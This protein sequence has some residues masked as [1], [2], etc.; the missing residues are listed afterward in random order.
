MKK[1]IITF[2]GILCILLATVLLLGFLQ[3]LLMPKYMSTS[4]E[5]GLIAEYY[6]EENPSH[7]VLFIGDCEVYESFRTLSWKP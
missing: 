7:D 1:K 3:A 6:R 2:T 5:G 4:R